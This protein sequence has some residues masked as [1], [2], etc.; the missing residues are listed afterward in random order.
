MKINEVFFDRLSSACNDF[1][2]NDKRIL[3]YLKNNRK[4]SDETIKNYCLGAFPKDLR[5]L[6]SKYNMNPVEL[7]QNNIIWNA[8]KSQ[9]SLYPIVIPIRNACGNTIAIGCRTLLSEDNRKKIGIPKY[10][11]SNY[12][13]TAYLFGLD[14]AKEEIRNE[15]CVFVVEGYFDVITAHQNGIKNVVATCGTMFSERQLSNLSRYCDNVCLLF[16]NDSAGR[17]SAGLLLDK[18][19]NFDSSINISCKFVPDGYKDLDEY[20]LDGGS[21]KKLK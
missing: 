1:L 10:R 6:Y 11:N 2:K 3:E 18:Y 17:R 19:S 16:D 20:L 21:F 7:K 5:V 14:K 4:M 12:K 9:F 15:N 8:S 13:K